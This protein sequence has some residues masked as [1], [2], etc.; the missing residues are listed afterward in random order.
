MSGDFSDKA[1]GPD[2]NA[3][4]DE[5]PNPPNLAGPAT[6]NAQ[7]SNAQADD[8]L[9]H[10]ERFGSVLEEYAPRLIRFLEMR[11]GSEA[12]AQDL[13]Q[14][15][16]FR[17]C[18]V[19]NPDLIREPEAYLFRIASNLAN[20]LVLRRRNQPTSF[21]R[22]TDEVEATE[23]DNGSFCSH[24]E[25]R[26]EIDRLQEILSELP[27]LYQAILLLRKRDGFSHKEIAEQLAI[28]PHTV[29]KYL[30]RALLR[31]RTLWAERYED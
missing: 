17:L 16:Y 25:K 23:G 19:K 3:R 28:S 7:T 13:A 10:D 27:P 11:T 9:T 30:T 1:V 31:C 14:E 2:K 8:A 18:R 5:S 12:D 22:G 20:E 24:L 15:A 21:A 4:R 29:Q 6:S 26:S